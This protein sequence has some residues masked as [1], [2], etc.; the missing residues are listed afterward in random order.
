MIPDLHNHP[1]RF[2]MQHYLDLTC[3]RREFDRVTEQIRQHLDDLVSVHL[4]LSIMR[5]IFQQNMM[6]TAKLVL[7]YNSEDKLTKVK[8]LRIILLGS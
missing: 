7:V 1:L 4:N 2:I 3:T 6:R 8:R 5:F